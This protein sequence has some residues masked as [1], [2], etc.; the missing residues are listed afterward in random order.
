MF[1]SFYLASSLIVLKQKSFNERLVS[2]ARKNCFLVQKPKETA[3]IGA[4]K[5]A[6]R[7]PDAGLVGK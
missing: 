6:L 7:V 2:R 3:A 4:A 1:D 5:I